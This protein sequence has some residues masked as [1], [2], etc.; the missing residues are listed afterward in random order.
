MEVHIYGLR[1][2]ESFVDTY[3][4]L[5]KSLAAICNMNYNDARSIPMVFHN[6]TIVT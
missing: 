5:Y 3:K 2:M 4:L 6:L 1:K